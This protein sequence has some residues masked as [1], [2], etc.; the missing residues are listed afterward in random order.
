MGNGG[1]LQRNGDHILLSILDTLANCLGN[2]SCLTK[3]Y[4]DVTVLVAHNHES[5]EAS[6]TTTLNGLG[7]TVQS[8]ERFLQLELC[9]IKLV[10][11]SFVSS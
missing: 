3:T 5:C 4:T 8:D 1:T 9:R 11:H 7:N 10:S 2:L 6:H